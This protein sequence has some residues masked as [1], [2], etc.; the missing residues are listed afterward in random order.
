MAAV[1]LGL[2]GAA[3]LWHAPAAESLTAAS[4]SSHP[5]W[6][7]IWSLPQTDCTPPTGKPAHRPP[8]LISSAEMR[9]LASLMNCPP[10]VRS[11]LPSLWSSR[12]PFIVS[13]NTSHSALRLSLETRFCGAQWKWWERVLC[14]GRGRCGFELIEQQRLGSPSC[15]I[16]GTRL[17]YTRMRRY[18]RKG[19]GHRWLAAGTPPAQNAQA[20]RGIV[21]NLSMPR[22]NNQS[23]AP[24]AQLPP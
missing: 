22:C 14:R 15:S 7:A 13:W 23:V 24:S 1:H 8:H 9:F 16:F 2:P 10:G 17:Q 18:P 6:P 12:G 4:A 21:S 20:S 19:K 11:W 5:V 3:A